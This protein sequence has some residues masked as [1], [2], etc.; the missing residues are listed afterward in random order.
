MSGERPLPLAGIKVVEF[1][2]I[3]PAPMAAM[4][5][6]DFG[7]EVILVTRPGG[8]SAGL[9]MGEPPIL[10]RGKR[11]ITLDLQ[12]PDDRRFAVDLLSEADVLVEG[13][14][15][16]VMERLGLGPDDLA[17]V[18]PG[19]VYTRVTG[20]GQEGPYADQV[21]HDL[22]YIGVGGP[23]AQIG[24]DAPTP[25][26]AFVG[27][28]ASGSL[29]AVIG[30]LLALRARELTGRGQV[31]D[32]A[33][34]DGST[35]LMSAHFEMHNRKVLRPRGENPMDGN[36][37][38]YATYVCAD[39]GWYS[40]A[41]VEPRF[42]ANLLDR[43]DLTDEPLDA[44][45]DQSRWPALRARIADRFRTATRAEWDA[46]FAGTEISA[47]P[48]L[49]IDELVDNPHIAARNLVRESD[50]RLEARPSPLLSE[51]PGRWGTWLARSGEHSAQ[52]REEHTT[53]R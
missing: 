22:N 29:M 15:P 34:V 50:G 5:L 52:I 4:M 6:C 31:V 12:D 23:L 13:Y 43:L 8:N 39:G 41:A 16:G 32:A 17:E 48:V 27:D 49:E 36:A 14:R 28:F 33:I 18:N 42:Y 20:W 45:Y 47:G 7:A 51:T 35:Y 10:G 26:S 2:S 9:P 37:P 11:A 3:A 40:V 19:L 25:P 53:S 46:R 21:G 1:Q 38:F 24:R 44:Q 30:T